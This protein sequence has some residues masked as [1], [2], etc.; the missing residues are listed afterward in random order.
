[1]YI[2]HL[3]LLFHYPLFTIHYSLF[4]IPFHFSLFTIFND[5]EGH[6]P[7][8]IEDGLFFAESPAGDV[9]S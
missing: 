5:C 8:I 9:V 7:E 6:C 1:M 2:T 4:T 3:H